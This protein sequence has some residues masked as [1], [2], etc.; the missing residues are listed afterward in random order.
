M[1]NSNLPISQLQL[2]TALTGLELLPFAADSANGAMFVSLLAAFIRQGM[3]TLAQVNARQP[4]LTSGYGIEITPDNVIK[5]TLDAKP[6]K[7][8][9]ALPTEDI[10]EKMYLIPDPNGKDNNL[11]IEYIWVEDHWEEV[12]KFKAT[13]DLTP[14]ET[15]EHATQTYATK[16]EL[17]G[18]VTTGVYDT[19]SQTVTQLSTLVTQ[20]KN[21]LD[22]IPEMPASDDGKTYGLSTGAWVEIAS[23][24]EAVAV[25]NKE[26]TEQS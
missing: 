17:E 6:F 16:T 8:V 24:T 14:Y 25:V 7:V 23:E 19:L 15:T 26:V 22:T 4:M 10:E 20:L 18:Y 2:A 13:I 1:K 9:N 3:A 12:G 5:T 21:K 11:Y